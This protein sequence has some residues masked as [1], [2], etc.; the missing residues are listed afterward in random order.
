M[1]EPNIHQKNINENLE[2]FWLGNTPLALRNP[3]TFDAC[4]GPTKKKQSQRLSR[5]ADDFFGVAKR[6]QR[7]VIVQLHGT[8]CADQSGRADLG[9]Q[10]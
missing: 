10:T 8:R 5:Y 6:K 1:A 4:T 7:E 2:I 9:S 3:N